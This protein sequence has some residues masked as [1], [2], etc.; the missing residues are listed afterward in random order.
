MT[1]FC[2]Y[3]PPPV[4][5]YVMCYGASLWLNSS[6]MMSRGFTS[7]TSV[8][9]QH[10]NF[11]SY[12]TFVSEFTNSGLLCGVLMIIEACLE[13][14]HTVQCKFLVQCSLF[15]DM[16]FKVFCFLPFY[17]ISHIAVPIR[18]LP[19]PHYFLDPFAVTNLSSRKE[20]S[21]FNSSVLS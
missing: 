11:P 4:Y 16:K 1:E 5:Y 15:R 17:S 3:P 21:V 7:Q 18:V 8:S 12:V 10:L 20:V 9:C 6:Q 19:P 2:P 13:E 14:N